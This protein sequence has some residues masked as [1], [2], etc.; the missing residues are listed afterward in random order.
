MS[1]LQPGLKKPFLHHFFSFVNPGDEVLIA[2][3][4]YIAYKTIIKMLD[5]IVVE[6]DL[7]P[8][9]GF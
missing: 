1:A 2:N 8:E 7:N 5:A 9:L 3:P 4:T 6:F